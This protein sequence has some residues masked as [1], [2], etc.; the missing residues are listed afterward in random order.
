MAQEDEGVLNVNQYENDA[1]SYL[2]IFAQ[3]NYG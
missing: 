3:W 2:L 1:V